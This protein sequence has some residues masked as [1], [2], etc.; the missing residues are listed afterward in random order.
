[1]DSLT[2]L[3]EVYNSLQARKVKTY[4]DLN[5]LLSNPSLSPDPVGDAKRYIN[6]IANLEKQ[7]EVTVFF[8]QQ[9]SPQEAP[10]GEPDDQEEDNDDMGD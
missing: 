9:L 7:Q 8:N 5:R 6:E 4:D 1:M 3:N 2:I 10:E